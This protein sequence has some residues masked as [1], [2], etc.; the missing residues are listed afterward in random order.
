MLAV[1]PNSK[2]E[3]ETSFIKTPME[4]LHWSYRLPLILKEIGRCDP[5][6]VCLEEVDRFNDIVIDGYDKIFLPKVKSPCTLFQPNNG[7][8][9]CA[10]LYKTSKV[11]LSDRRDIVL[12][13]EANRPTSQVGLLAKF[14]IVGKSGGMICVGVTHL[15][16]KGGFEK[17]RHAQGLSLFRS[18]QEFIHPSSA[19]ECPFVICGDFNAI[20]SEDVCTVYRSLEGGVIRSAYTHYTGSEPEFTTMK[21]RASG[22]SKYTGD[23]IWY[24]SHKLTLAQ[25]YDLMTE[26]H[27][28][29]D[30]GLPNTQYPSDHMALC[31]SFTLM[32]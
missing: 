14:N 31:A 18:L 20:P 27:I 30:V 4:Y 23:Y 16:A 6:I 17:L 21:Y 29:T 1:T 8:D 7:P 25:V 5:D 22:L 3:L 12:E 11:T 26:E 19:M 28:G 9:G 15:K 2:G 13:D 24:N 32:N 10:I